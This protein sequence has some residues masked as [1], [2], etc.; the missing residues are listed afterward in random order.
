M[1]IFLVLVI[2]YY[3]E[4]IFATNVRNEINKIGIL[5]EAQQDEYRLDKIEINNATKGP[6]S[7]D[8]RPAN[9]LRRHTAHRRRHKKFS[10]RSWRNL[11]RYRRRRERR[12]N[13]LGPKFGKRSLEDRESP[14]LERE[15][16]NSNEYN[17]EKKD[18][19]NSIDDEK[20]MEWDLWGHWAPCS[21]TCG[22]GRR[23]RWRHCVGENCDIEGMK[24]AQIKP[25]YRKKCT[26]SILSW[27]GIESGT[28]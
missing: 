7:V 26:E 9:R 24:Q 22:T 23:V 16:I 6:F 21:V 3:L 10:P 27:L 2:I 25:C 4:W 15:I 12:E 28:K 11:G 17:E 13:W 5:L 14:N 8:F 20:E 1:Q 19:D 18:D